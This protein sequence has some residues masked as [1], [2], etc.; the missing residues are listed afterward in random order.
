MHET[1]RAAY[2]AL[3]ASHR[4]PAILDDALR[5]VHAPP[6]GGAAYA[7]EVIGAGLVE[8]LGNGETFNV[9]RLRGYCRSHA[10]GPPA[11]G[12]AS[13]RP[14]PTEA[15]SVRAGEQTL[16]ASQVWALCVEGGLCGRGQ[17]RASL[18]ERIAALA[19]SGKVSDAG[20]FVAL[21]LAIKPWELGEIAF[22]KSRD[23][24]LLERLA[25]WQ[26]RAA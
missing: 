11:S 19:A 20:A 23:E 24:Q 1:H 10:A 22:A 12:R 26:R 6:T 18:E 15:A 17:S 4:S 13:A 7:W 3:R 5:T 2:L 16:S 9:S 25:A 14:S 21:V 8:S